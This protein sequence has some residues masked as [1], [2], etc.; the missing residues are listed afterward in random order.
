M[1]LFNALLV[2]FRSR[3]NLTRRQTKGQSGESPNDELEGCRAIFGVVVFAGHGWEA[4]MVA[5]IGVIGFAG[6]DLP[7]QATRCR[8]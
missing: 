4:T 8:L 5:P 6:F 1:G 2:A 3:K 7:P